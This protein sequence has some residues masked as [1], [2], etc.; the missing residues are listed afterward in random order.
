MR[1]TVLSRSPTAIPVVYD[2]PLLA[3]SALENAM[4][5]PQRDQNQPRVNATSQSQGDITEPMPT[6]RPNVPN[7][8][9]VSG[10]EPQAELEA[11]STSSVVKD[12]KSAQLFSESE[13]VQHTGSTG[14][15][16]KLPTPP[17]SEVEMAAAMLQSAMEH[18]MTTL[19]ASGTLSKTAPEA[20]V[21]EGLSDQNVSN[22]DSSSSSYSAKVD[23]IE[24]GCPHEQVVSQPGTQAARPFKC[25]PEDIQ[26]VRR[27]RNE[28]I[29]YPSKAAPVHR[30]G[31]QLGYLGHDKE[32]PFISIFRSRFSQT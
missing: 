31:A 29:R 3:Y 9:I 4:R 25:T 13:E 20:E 14:T 24:P 18:F 5:R 32:P 27:L 21:R 28:P 12:D 17:E 19:R 26:R 22:I 23:S 11:T 30:N 15:Q 1:A 10:L 2:G 6:S 7:A 8:D 16:R